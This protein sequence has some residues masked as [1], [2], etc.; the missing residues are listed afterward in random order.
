LRALMIKLMRPMRGL[1]QQHEARVADPLEERI[2]VLDRITQR[3]SMFTHDL[4]DC[5]FN[6]LFHT[7]L[8]G[9]FTPAAPRPVRESRRADG[10]LLRELFARSPGTNAPR[11]LS[12]N[13]PL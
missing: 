11:L 6:G 1:A 7:N 5:C 8:A 3:M 10:G 12:L 13:N 4:A 2:I 9:R